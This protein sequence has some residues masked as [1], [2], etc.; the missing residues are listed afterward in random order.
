MLASDHRRVDLSL[1]FLTGVSFFGLV[2]AGLLMVIPSISHVDF[3]WRKSV[4]GS[5]FG[6]ICVLG[7]LASVFPGACSRGF[8]LRKREGGGGHVHFG[9]GRGGSDYVGGSGVL[10]G[11]HPRC[12]VFSS[13][14]FRVGGRVLCASCSGLFLGG[15]LSLVG[16]ILYFFGGLSVG[17]GAMLVGFV[18]LVGVAVGLLQCVLIRVDWGFV[19]VLSGSVFAVGAF[20]VLVS[21]DELVGDLFLDVFVI[22]LT[23]FWILTRVSLSR[24]EHDGMCSGCDSVSCVLDEG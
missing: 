12:G 14:V 11:H 9:F 16:A 21:V 5:I 2:L 19:R 6:L 24:W 23:V 13:H 18:G 10:S 7:S 3:V 17:G 8:G 15:L 1:V 4:V 20:L 22:L